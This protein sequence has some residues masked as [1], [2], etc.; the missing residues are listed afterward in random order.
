MVVCNTLPERNELVSPKA[1][2]GASGCTGAVVRA[3]V[4]GMEDATSGIDAAGAAGAAGAGS[5]G[6][7]SLVVAAVLVDAAG[8][9]LGCPQRIS[10][11]FRSHKHRD[12]PSTPSTPKNP[13]P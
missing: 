7:G 13:S 11:P 10:F 3:A 8:V 9:G 2:A 4:E 6:T 5:A 1:G 12:K